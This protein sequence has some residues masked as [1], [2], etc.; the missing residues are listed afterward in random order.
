MSD[1]SLAPSAPTHCKATAARRQP[2]RV[3]RVLAA[4]R[5]GWACKWSVG[6]AKADSVLSP[7]ACPQK[8]FVVVA[9]VGRREPR[10]CEPFRGADTLVSEATTFVAT[11]ACLTMTRVARYSVSR[12]ASYSAGSAL[13]PTKSEAT[14]RTSVRSARSGGVGE[15]RTSVWKLTRTKADLD[16]RDR[17]RVSRP[18]RSALVRLNDRSDRCSSSSRPRWLQPARG[19]TI[20]AT[21]FVNPGQKARPRSLP[22]APVP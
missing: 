2:P 4:R 11:E 21:R 13:R 9:A 14:S 10:I 15:R 12:T 7:A 18:R 3:R 22:M 17:P 16:K 19:E 6:M 20:A 5:S 8:H 1:G